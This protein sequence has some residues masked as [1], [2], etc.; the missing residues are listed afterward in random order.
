M[1][2][3]QCGLDMPTEQGYLPLY[4]D[5]VWMCDDCA[6]DYR[7]DHPDPEQ[8]VTKAEYKSDLKEDR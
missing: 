5:K 8:V 4:V 3:E 7:A 1:K 6:Q 2:C